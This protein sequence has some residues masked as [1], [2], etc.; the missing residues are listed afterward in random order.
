MLA[1]P[2]KAPSVRAPPPALPQVLYYCDNYLSKYIAPTLE[3][4]QQLPTLAAIGLVNFLCTAPAFLIIDRF[5]RRPLLIFG[6]LGMAVTM[7]TQVRRGARRARPLP[8][9]SFLPLLG[10]A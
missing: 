7:F 1:P 4:G 8:G 10:R 2:C 5:G 3:D 9:P 6:A